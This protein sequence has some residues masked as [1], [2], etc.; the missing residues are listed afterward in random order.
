MRMESENATT[1]T[2]RAATTSV[3]RS[4]RDRA[5]TSSEGSPLGTGPVTDTPRAARSSAGRGDAQD[6]EKECAGDP[7]ADPAGHEQE[8]QG[9]GAD[10]D[11]GPVGVADV[12]E[13]VER[14]ADGPFLVAGDAD[15]ACRGWPRTSTI[16]TPVMYPTRTACEK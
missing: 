13:D 3:L 10:D 14:L 16:A 2:A 6:H 8:R 11:R 15:Q 5:G 7:L 1:K 9:Q 4:A 12:A